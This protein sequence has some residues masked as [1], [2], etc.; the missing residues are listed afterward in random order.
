M[1]EL[2]R[3]DRVLLA[4]V[5]SGNTLGCRT[6]LPDGRGSTLGITKDEAPKGRAGSGVVWPFCHTGKAAT[7]EGGARGDRARA[8]PKKEGPAKRDLVG[9]AADREGVRAAG[10]EGR[11]LRARTRGRRPHH[12]ERAAERMRGQARSATAH[13]GE[14]GG[15]AEGAQAP[16]SAHS[17]KRGRAPNEGRARGARCGPQH[18][19]LIL[20]GPSELR[21]FAGTALTH[22]SG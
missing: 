8:V 22:R 1:S 11:V 16:G 4:R 9:V 12:L 21:A 20:Y 7:N 2:S 13:N 15:G 18:T 6:R 14:E 19:A 17:P 10:A 3:R 5:R